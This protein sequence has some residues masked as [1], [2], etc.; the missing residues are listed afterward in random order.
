MQAPLAASHP[1]MH[2]GTVPSVALLRLLKAL[3]ARLPRPLFAVLTVGML[4]QPVDMGSQLRA[5]LAA[6]PKGRALHGSSGG[7]SR[8]WQMHARHVQYGAYKERSRISIDLGKVGAGCR[9]E[10]PCGPSSA[11]VLRGATG[12]LAMHASMGAA[13]AVSVSICPFSLLS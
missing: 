6:V 12:C 2:A 3:S 5:A 1:C 7:L 9:A 4:E 11:S 8:L 10:R 13:M